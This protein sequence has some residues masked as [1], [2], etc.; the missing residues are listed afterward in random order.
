MSYQLAWRECFGGH[1]ALGHKP[2]QKLRDELERTA[3]TLIV[4]LLSESESRSPASEHRLRLPL[5][6][7]A[8]PP[9]SRD[10]EVLAAF[11]QIRRELAA[12][13][14][15]YLH[16]SAGLH[17]TGMVAY[18]F[19]RC[20]GLDRDE[21][22]RRIRDLRELTATELTEERMAWGDRLARE[23]VTEPSAD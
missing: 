8:P 4:S 16:C 10:G 18:A 17:R 6:G 14:K 9:P 21:A 5:S 13:G 19:L 1:L 15:V 22:V 3:C 12:G 11:A 20:A 23:H 7:A 2:G